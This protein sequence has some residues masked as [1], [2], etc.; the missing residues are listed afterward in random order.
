MKQPSG[1]EETKDEEFQCWAAAGGS[2]TGASR[3][4]ALDGT[5]GA[6]LKRTEIPAD[7]PSVSVFATL[8][9]KSNQRVKGIIEEA[10]KGNAAPG[11]GTRKIADL[12]NSFM[13]EAG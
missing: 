3:S 4:G 5:N 2:G 1:C 11:S 13:D 12:Y 8:V 6:W 7:R 9:D 10:S